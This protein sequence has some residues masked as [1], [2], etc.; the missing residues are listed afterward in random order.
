DTIGRVRESGA[1]MAAVIGALV[2]DDV[3]AAARGLVER[4][5]AAAA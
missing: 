1:V 4:W 2:C 5:E 3:E